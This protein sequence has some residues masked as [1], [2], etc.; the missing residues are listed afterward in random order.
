M[1]NTVDLLLIKGCKEIFIEF[2]SCFVVC[3]KWFL[4][5]QAL[6]TFAINNVFRF[7]VLGNSSKELRCHRQEEELIVFSLVFFV[8]LSL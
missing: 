7:E 6:K 2:A 4:N 5:D 1:V 8:K 3:T